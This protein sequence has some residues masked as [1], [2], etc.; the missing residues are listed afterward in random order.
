MGRASRVPRKAHQ[1]CAE[2]RPL[3]LFIDPCMLNSFRYDIACNPP[4]PAPPPYRLRQRN[5]VHGFVEGLPVQVSQAPVICQVPHLHVHGA[6]RC[7]NGTASRQCPLS[8]L[9]NTRHPLSARG[10]TA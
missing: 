7:L 8:A 4:R 9:C 3:L 6:P 1:P 10:R 2:G 5:E